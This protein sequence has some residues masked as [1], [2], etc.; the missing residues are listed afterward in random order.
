MFDPESF[1]KAMENIIKINTCNGN[2]DKEFGHMEMDNLL[3]SLLCQLGY[4]KAVDIYKNTPKWY[5]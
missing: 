2:Y 1:A 5:S 3:C 4:R